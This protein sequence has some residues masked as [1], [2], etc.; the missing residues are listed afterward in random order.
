MKHRYLSQLS[1]KDN[2]ILMAILITIQLEKKI[3][4]H[5]MK[6]FAISP[7]PFALNDI[8]LFTYIRNISSN[9]IL[10]VY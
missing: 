10:N 4:G 3:K 6:L 5:H 7:S 1:P 2:I 8:V 9:N